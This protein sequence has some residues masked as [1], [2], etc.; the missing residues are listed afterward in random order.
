MREI[1]YVRVLDIMA[2]M[3]R[4]DCEIIYVTH[5]GDF[6]K[7]MK[8]ANKRNIVTTSISKAEYLRMEKKFQF[9]ENVEE[10]GSIDDVLKEWWYINE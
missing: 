1:F 7:L 10:Y 3:G 6:E 9:V 8:A 4:K 5:S 2:I